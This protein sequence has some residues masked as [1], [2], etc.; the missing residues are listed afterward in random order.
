MEN[1]SQPFKST[2]HWI[3]QIEK[4]I[5]E[6]IIDFLKIK[7][8]PIEKKYLSFLCAPWVH[9]FSHSALHRYELM[10]DI[11]PVNT[12][13]AHTSLTAPGDTLDF[14]ELSRTSEYATMLDNSLNG[15]HVTFKCRG[16]IETIDH[17][18]STRRT[19]TVAYKTGF[20]R[21]LRYFIPL[22]S[23]GKISI[24]DSSKASIQCS[25][26]SILR[27]E[28]SIYLSN[29]LTTPDPSLTIW[30]SEACAALFP[31]AILENLQSSWDKNYSLP[32][33]E[34]LFSANAWDIID[35]WKIYAITQKER[36][37]TRWVGS[38]HALNHGSS[39][40]FWQRNFELDYLDEYLTW[41]WSSDQN[42]HAQIQ[43]FHPPHF[44][45]KIKIPPKKYTWGKGILISSAG[46]PKHLL[47]YPYYPR[48]F[49]KYLVTQLLMAQELQHVTQEEV[50]IRS[51]P[52]DLGWDI[53][54]MISNLKNSKIKI[55]FQNGP[56]KKRLESSSIHICDNISTTIVE[57]LLCN[58]PTMVLMTHE[59]FDIHPQAKVAWQALEQAGIAHFTLNSLIEKINSIQKDMEVW[60]NSGN[61]QFAIRFFIENQAR[62]GGNIRIWT[63]KLLS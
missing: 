43:E 12:S 20:P 47:E 53:G 5:L 4:S 23:L 32:K 15:Q 60:W 38:P 19:L 31:L 10:R 62:D 7:N 34:K 13:F 14:L 57:S 55:E 30:L 51:R 21:K 3:I 28:F 48:D 44:P 58:H 22:I 63:K 50:T 52:K 6:V 27:D 26:N 40:I 49:E 24:I 41:G 61:T 16:N 39:S 33:R 25:R 35:E 37:Q 54:A 9:F 36:F 42:H 11:K 18:K 29:K 46:R 56:F 17:K 2:P 59:Y 45:Q 8:P 1:F